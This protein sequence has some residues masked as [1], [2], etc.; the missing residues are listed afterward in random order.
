MLPLDICTRIVSI[1]DRPVIYQDLQ[2]YSMHH[3][4]T[5]FITVWYPDSKS[6]IELDGTC[7]ACGN[8]KLLPRLYPNR[9]FGEIAAWA[10]L[11]FLL[12]QHPASLA[13]KTYLRVQL[14]DT[15]ET[16][17][18]LPKAW[19][20]LES[21]ANPELISARSRHVVNRFFAK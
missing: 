3:T 18:W 1:Q 4:L 20:V 16:P 9:A 2:P 11:L 7:L 15:S 14:C 13:L 10:V 17:L 8:S 12:S 19:Q 6:V 5:S 21:P